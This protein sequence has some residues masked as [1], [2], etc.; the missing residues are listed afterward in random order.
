MAED[1]DN[2]AQQSG[3]NAPRIACFG[4]PESSN[5]Y[6]LMIEKRVLC[7]VSGSFCKALLLW[8]IS[9]YVFHLEYLKDTYDLALFFQEFVL[10]LPGTGSAS[11]K[12]STYL[13]VCSD[14]QIYSAH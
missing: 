8:F 5:T 7:E 4:D 13:T 12:T 1:P 14:I 10:G 6:Y 11:K 2:V 9:H 3:N